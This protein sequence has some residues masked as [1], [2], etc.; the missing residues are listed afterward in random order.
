MLM[1][2]SFW[3]LFYHLSTGAG[4]QHFGFLPQAYSHWEPA[5]STSRPAHLAAWGEPAQPSSSPQ[6]PHEAG[7]HSWPG[8]GPGMPTSTPMVFSLTTTKGYMQLT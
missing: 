6:Q 7:P 8:C 2:T 5:P 4:N 3:I 1:A